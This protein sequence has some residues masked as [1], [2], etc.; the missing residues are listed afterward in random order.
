MGIL[1]SHIAFMKA[2]KA[3]GIS[4]DTLPWKAP[5]Q[6]YAAYVA[7]VITAIVTLFKGASDARPTVA[8]FA[9]AVRF[10]LTCAPSPGFDS[11]IPKFNYKTFITNYCA[12]P[13]WLALY[14]CVLSPPP[15]A[16]SLRRRLAL[17]PSLFSALPDC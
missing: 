10:V 8:P 5:L 3:Q 1:G 7:F 4:R 17:F 16:H 6:P 15:R 9:H 11:F 12:V 2:L 14:L 13:F